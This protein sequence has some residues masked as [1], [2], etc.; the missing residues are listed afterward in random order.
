[1]SKN[2]VGAAIDHG[3]EFIRSVQETDGSF[4]SHSCRVETP[5]S[6]TKKHQT[7]FIPALILSALSTIDS[8]QNIRQRLACW[9]NGQKSGIWSFNYWSKQ[10]PERKTSPYPD[11]LD[12]TFCALIG[13]YMHDPKLVDASALG[14]I[15]KLLIA[16]ESQV[17]GP[18][19]TWLAPEDSPDIWLDTD[20]A[21]NSNIA[22]LLR[23]VAQPLPNLDKMLERA[24]DNRCFGSPY[25][26]S[27]LPVLYYVA[28]A[29]R[30]QKQQ[31]LAQYI[32]SLDWDTPQKCA[33]AISAANKL[34]GVSD[35]RK[36]RALLDT[37]RPDGSWPA[38]AFCY[39][40]ERL[41]RPYYYG[42]PALTTALAIEALSCQEH[43]QAAKQPRA[44][45]SQAKNYKKLLFLAKQE[46]SRLGDS[47]RVR[48]TATVD[49]MA[50]SD[51]TKEILL[52]PQLFAG[53][54]SKL[55]EISEETFAQLSMASLYGWMAYTIY[56]DF[57]DGE[58]EPELLP[59]ANVALRDSL[60]AFERAIPGDSAFQRQVRCTFDTIDNANSWEV[61]N[62][63]CPVTKN[64]ITIGRI[65]RY[66]A[67]H[68]L[69]DRSLGHT[70]TP[71]AIMVLSG[72]SLSSTKTASVQSGL[73]HYLI[74]RQ[75]LDDAHDWEDDVRNGHISYVV[76]AIL[77]GLH[78]KPGTYQL[79]DLV[80]KLQHQ[81][82]HHT[83]QKTCNHIE[84]HLNSA[85][86]KF[87]QSQLIK[88]ESP[89][90][91]LLDKLSTTVKHTRAEQDQAEDFLKAYKK[92]LQES[93]EA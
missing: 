56:D 31:A 54:L 17:G 15:V 64:T 86:Q 26:P 27:S 36:I 59:V 48:S 68:N 20:L 90:I 4:V 63:R 42:A 82:W 89:L 23:I 41:G 52:M 37:Q 24:I 34:G 43:R 85:R 30:G 87:D 1:M 13:L 50:K 33:I 84:Q 40:P 35:P 75:L 91:S 19:R 57:L 44:A 53:S 3:L 8:A 32:A 58:G 61:T 11:D 92:P 81:F 62:C 2:A 45:N 77:L 7:I 10:S 65:P 14:N 21:V 51:T 39:E 74:A 60:E 67:G 28:R 49:F 29:Y 47:L 79:D 72:Q 5:F 55:P 83:L 6:C 16:N 73:C 66:G 80:P 70:L 46:L 18:Y 9:L 76:A 88:P 69:A 78:L 38:E 71:Q 25:Y 93:E 22:C 12:D